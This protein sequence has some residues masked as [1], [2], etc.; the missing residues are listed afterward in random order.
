[1]IGHM[2][3]RGGMTPEELQQTAPAVF[4]DAP[5]AATSERGSD[6]HG[7][8]IPLTQCCPFK[9]NRISDMVR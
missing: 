6:G 9:T 3:A 4:A 1:M 7:K 5:H 8:D 2:H